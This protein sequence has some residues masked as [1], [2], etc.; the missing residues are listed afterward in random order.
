M[1]FIFIY[2][3]LVFI[4]FLNFSCNSTNPVYQATKE[5][6]TD[7]SLLPDL[8]RVYMDG[9]LEKDLAVVSINQGSA[10]KDLLRIQVN[11]KNKIEWMNEDGIVFNDSSS[12]WMPLSL[13]GAEIVAVQSIASSPLAKNFWLKVQRA[14]K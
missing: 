3:Y 4:V 8:K 7:P 14:K 1:K 13:R 12:V 5:D 11:L 9:G 2:L 10:N 6:P